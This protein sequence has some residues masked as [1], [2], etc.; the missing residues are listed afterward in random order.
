MI[1]GGVI[2][3]VGSL[4]L[5]VSVMLGACSIFRSSGGSVSAA[6][7]AAVQELNATY[8]S[9]WLEGDPDRIIALFADDAVLMPH[10]GDAMVERL[11]AIR[12]HF[13][14]PG[15]PPTYVSEFSMTPDE[16]TASGKLAYTRG[17]FSLTMWWNDVDGRV[18]YSNAGNYL[19]VV[20]KEED[21]DWR[22]SRY[23]WSDPVVDLQ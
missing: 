11:E 6:D 16:I 8:P 9:A 19:M 23:M 20:S 21:G 15:A 22:I 7:L 5:A 12:R 13:W 4:T 3:R 17:R 1:R 2:V 14:P 10:H 18:T